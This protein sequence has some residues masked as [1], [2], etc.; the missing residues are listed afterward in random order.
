MQIKEH[1]VVICSAGHDS[2]SFVHQLCRQCLCIVDNLLLVYIEVLFHGFLEAN[3][4]GCNNMHQ[5]ATLY[6]R[7]N[8][9]VNLLGKFALAQNHTASWASQCLVSSCSYKIC[10]FNWIWM[11]FCSNKS[12]NVSHVNHEVSSHFICNFSESLEVYES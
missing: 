12:C 11:K 7:E 5:R 2:E 9:L 1:K 4:F 8:C 6:S 10:I 3:S